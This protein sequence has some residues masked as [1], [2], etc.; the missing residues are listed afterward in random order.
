MFYACCHSRMLLKIQHMFLV[1][2]VLPLLNQ[3]L[4]TLGYSQRQQYCPLIHF[5]VEQ[6][7]EW[8]FL[9]TTVEIFHFFVFSEV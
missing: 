6:S 1:E 9:S 7:T 8:C 5:Y 2:K 4:H 3:L